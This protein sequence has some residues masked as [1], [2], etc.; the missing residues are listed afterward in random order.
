M[1]ENKVSQLIC[2]EYFENILLSTQNSKIKKTPKTQRGRLLGNINKTCKILVSSG[3]EYNAAYLVLVP[4]MDL[5]VN[6]HVCFY[7]SII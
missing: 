6:A 4:F 7:V 3:L 5:Q 2:K 1:E